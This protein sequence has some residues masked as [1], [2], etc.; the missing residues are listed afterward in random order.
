MFL[1]HKN[2]SNVFVANLSKKTSAPNSMDTISLV[3]HFVTF[4]SSFVLHTNCLHA[5]PCTVFGPNRKM[6]RNSCT[7]WL[8]WRDSREFPRGRRREL[9]RFL[10]VCI[11]LP[12]NPLCMPG[13]HRLPPRWWPCKV[14]PAGT[15]EAAGSLVD[16]HCPQTDCLVENCLDP[17][18]E[19]SD[20]MSVVVVRCHSQHWEHMEEVVLLAFVSLWVKSG[21]ST[22][23]WWRWYGGQSLTYYSRTRSISKHKTVEM[24]NT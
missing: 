23:L 22:V 8:S 24:S 9:E 10:L 4:V 5:V 11:D 21:T 1:I 14:P 6:H 13:T 19:W 16:S 7:S 2:I 12:D 15:A 18:L 3:S 17:A 20:C